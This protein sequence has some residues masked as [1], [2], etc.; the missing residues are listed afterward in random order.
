M[1]TIAQWH[2][3]ELRAPNGN[4]VGIFYSPF[5]VPLALRTGVS[6]VLRLFYASSVFMSV[7]G[8]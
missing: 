8:I 3:G 7:N 5:G 4:L 6:A 1:L 2:V